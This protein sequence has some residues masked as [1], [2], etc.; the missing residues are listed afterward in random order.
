[1]KRLGI[2]IAAAIAAALVTTNCSDDDNPTGPGNGGDEAKTGYTCFMPLNVGNKWTYNRVYRHS[3]GTYREATFEYEVVSTLEDYHGYDAYLIQEKAL[4]QVVYRVAGCDGD[5]C[6]LYTCPWWEYLIE[7]DMEW[8]SF[9]Q[10]GFFSPYRLKYN[11][12]ENISVPAGT[13]N[14]CKQLNT[15]FYP[16]SST[17]E[18]HTEYYAR[19]VG[20][21]NA[22]LYYDSGGTY[23]YSYEYKLTSYHIVSP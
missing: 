1:M 17:S 6:Y 19:D 15:V 23:W 18:T 4:G 21:V 5:K 14:D 8:Q 20:L 9:S 12:I 7:D 2:L 3:V 13:F 22:I 10:T 16:T 11:S